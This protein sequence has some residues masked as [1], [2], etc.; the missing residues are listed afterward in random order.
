[1]AVSALFS[2]SLHPFGIADARRTD[3]HLRLEACRR[4]HWCLGLGLGWFIDPDGCLLSSDFTLCLRCQSPGCPSGLSCSLAGSPF[5]HQRM[6]FPLDSWGLQQCKLVGHQAASPDRSREC[7]D[8]RR[9]LVC[10]SAPRILTRD[11]DSGSARGL[12]RRGPEP[13]GVC[14]DQCGQQKKCCL[15]SASFS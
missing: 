10:G 6:F 15:H 7:L 2:R 5:A 8:S 14:P 13:R 11:D 1:M 12:L 3:A 4:T 9:A